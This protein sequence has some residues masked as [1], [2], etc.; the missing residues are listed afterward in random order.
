MIRTTR[1]RGNITH[2]RFHLLVRRAGFSILHLPGCDSAPALRDM[3]GGMIQLMVNGSNVGKFILDAGRVCAL[4]FLG[5]QRV[6]LLLPDL[7]NAVEKHEGAGG[8]HRERHDQA[9]RAPRHHDAPG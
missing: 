7:P 2:L 4:A 8:V 1:A 3:L 6:L 5:P 9:V